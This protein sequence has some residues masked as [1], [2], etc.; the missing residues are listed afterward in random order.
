MCP[1][2]FRMK[3]IT[4]LPLNGVHRRIRRCNVF[5]GITNDKKYS[6]VI[7]KIADNA[8]KIAAGSNYCD[9]MTKLYTLPGVLMDPAGSVTLLDDVKTSN[10]YVDDFKSALTQV[11]DICTRELDN[12]PISFNK[13]SDVGY[14]Y[15]TKSMEAKRGIVKFILKNYKVILDLVHKG[16]WAALDSLEIPIIPCY[17]TGLRLQSDSNEV[18]NGHIIPKERNAFTFEGKEVLASKLLPQGFCP[19]VFA[20][21][22]RV[23]WKLNWC[24]NVLLNF[25]SNAIRR[26]MKRRFSFTWKS[27]GA[28]L[29]ILQKAPSGW[30]RQSY[31]AKRFDTQQ[32]RAFLACLFS[33]FKRNLNSAFVRLLEVSTSAPVMYGQD[34][35]G[36]KG[37]K[38]MGNLLNPTLGM[39][40]RDY[41]DPSGIS[42]IDV[43]NKIFMLA[44]YV[45]AAQECKF[46]DGSDRSVESLLRG[47]NPFIKIIDMGDDSDVFI[48]SEVNTRLFDDAINNFG[49]SVFPIEKKG[50]EQWLGHIVYNNNNNPLVLPMLSNGLA[51]ILIPERS[52]DSY[53]R[54]NSWGIGYFARQKDV[55]DRHP[56]WQQLWSESIGILNQEYSTD[57]DSLA[58]AARNE[59]LK[60]ERT[61]KSALDYAFLSNPDYIHY[62]FM[63][64]EVSPDVLAEYYFTLEAAECEEITRY[65]AAAG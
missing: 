15:F 6:F 43:N 33:G 28:A 59:S 46:I 60:I 30:I 12:G 63:A 29:D 18:R 1:H 14:P 7:A 21:R 64:E 3:I 48:N 5:P 32:K 10:R 17:T 54:I 2:E 9:D 50:V 36:K 19:R 13:L 23:Y 49:K 34:S 26:A 62:R 55:Y 22:T 42:F 57:V 45:L 8:M 56:L 44:I 24:V 61:V 31:D 51:N 11:A 58:I 4:Q 53:A 65:L 39:D 38:I 16:D 47:E 40:K 20:M 37:F 25:G 27:A 41:G 52:Y 35:D